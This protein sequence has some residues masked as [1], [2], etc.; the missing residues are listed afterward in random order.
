MMEESKS[1]SSEFDL[2]IS[3]NTSFLYVDLTK[4]HHQEEWLIFQAYFEVQVTC[5]FFQDDTPQV[6]VYGVDSAGKLWKMVGRW[7]Q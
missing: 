6:K 4:Q 7:K 2:I 3:N 5:I 1:S